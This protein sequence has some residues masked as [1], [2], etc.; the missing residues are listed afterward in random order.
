MKS[1]M[2]SKP[3]VKKR[4]G[5]SVEQCETKT[6]VESENKLDFTK[7]NENENHS[8]VCD[9]IINIVSLSKSR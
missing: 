4:C 1:T 5:K 6:A 3:S 8:Y 2:R 9:F 7:H